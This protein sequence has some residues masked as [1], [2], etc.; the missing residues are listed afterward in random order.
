MLFL[1]PTRQEK[2]VT[3]VGRLSPDRRPRSP[4]Q[5]SSSEM[6]TANLIRREPTSNYDHVA[7][8]G[9]TSEGLHSVL[10]A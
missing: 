6:P 2:S 10:S 7:T 9:G 4:L 8:Q 3:T 1:D 5:I